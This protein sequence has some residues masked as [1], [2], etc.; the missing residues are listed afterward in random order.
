M[1][2]DFCQNNRAKELLLSENR[3]VSPPC[4]GSGMKTCTVASH[5]KGQI[6]V[7]VNIFS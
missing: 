1:K 6:F 5:C 4:R 3:L 7:I 2:F